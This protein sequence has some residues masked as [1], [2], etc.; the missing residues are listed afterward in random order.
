MTKSDVQ[1]ISPALGPSNLH[2]FL[3]CPAPKPKHSMSFPT[4]YSHLILPF[5]TPTAQ[6]LMW[7]KYFATYR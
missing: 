2:L 3:V 5:H 4:Y 1:K 6:T 7:C